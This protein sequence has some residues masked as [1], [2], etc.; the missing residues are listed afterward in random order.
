MSVELAHNELW[1]G[2]INTQLGDLTSSNGEK[3]AE[4]IWLSGGRLGAGWSKLVY[5]SNFLK[6]LTGMLYPNQVLPEILIA[7]EGAPE[8]AASEDD[9]LVKKIRALANESRS[10]DAEADGRIAVSD[11]T[12][13]L[14][15][16]AAAKLVA[17]ERRPHNVGITGEGKIAFGWG[18]PSTAAMITV[19][20]NGRL[21]ISSKVG[22]DIETFGSWGVMEPIPKHYLDLLREHF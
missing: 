15:L 19:G 21:R 14:A 3:E 7:V 5:L 8:I 20:D 12:E 2:N 17:A 4:G 16:N 10:E 18:G 22:R 6:P 11:F 9:P 13:E 1:L